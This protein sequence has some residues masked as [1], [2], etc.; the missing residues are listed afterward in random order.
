MTDED[1][2]HGAEPL[3]LRKDPAWVRE[4]ISELPPCGR[5]AGTPR[6]TLRSWLLQ[7][8]CWRTASG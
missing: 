7:I 3:G 8:W 6:P 5:K 2:S 4:V 1:N